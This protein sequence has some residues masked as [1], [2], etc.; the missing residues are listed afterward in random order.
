MQY[1]VTKGSRLGR[2]RWASPILGP[3]AAGGPFITARVAT[4]ERDTP[5]AARLILTVLRQA[6]L[7]DIFQL[8]SE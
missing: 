6:H 3:Y 4:L 5:T 2:L 8:P 1:R 7:G